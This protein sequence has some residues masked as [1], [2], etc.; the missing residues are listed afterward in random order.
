MSLGQRS[1]T[2]ESPGSKI[3]GESAIYGGLNLFWKPTLALDVNVGY[4]HDVMIAPRELFTYD[5]LEILSFWRIKDSLEMYVNGFY[6]MVSDDNN[7]LNL[8]GRLAWTVSEKQ[9]FRLGLNGHFVTA[10]NDSEYY[11]TP[12]WLQRYYIFGEFKKSYRNTYAR[13]EVR[14]GVSDEGVRDE[15]R[16]E[17]NE[18]AYRA[19][20]EGWYPGPNPDQ[21]WESIMGVTAAYRRKFF[22]QFE[23]FGELNVDYV[24]S[25]SEQEVL[26]GV[27]WNFF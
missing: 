5:G 24:G 11:W 9:N 10:D 14:L 21:G 4:S 26:I 12:F 27:T 13:F 2:S 23:F 8:S 19:E 25:Y 22:N 15:E 17:F 18:K 7:L 3:D 20:T 6:Q 16:D 1:Y